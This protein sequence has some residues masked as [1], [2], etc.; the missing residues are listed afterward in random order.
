MPSGADLFEL[1]FMGPGLL[2]LLLLVLFA[3]LALLPR[4][5][6]RRHTRRVERAA[7]LIESGRTDAGLTRL[8]REIARLRHRRSTPA[9]ATVLVGVLG[10][11]ASEALVAGHTDAA[12]AA[13]TEAA[14]LSARLHPNDLRHAQVL[15]VLGRTLARLGHDERALAHLRQAVLTGDA[16][17]HAD[18]ALTVRALFAANTSMVLRRTGDTPAA[19]TMATRAVHLASI[20]PPEPVPYMQAGSGFAYTALALAQT[21]SGLDGR[22]AARTALETFRRLDQEKILPGGEGIALACYTAAYAGHRQG[23]E[24]AVDL[25]REAAERF[26]DLGRPGDALHERRL[27]DASRLLAEI[28][29]GRPATPAEDPR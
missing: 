10:H 6:H 27:A 3:I 26:S 12:L 16:A 14:E 22:V 17:D 19:L 18:Q 7:K 5:A 24:Q 29:S 20:A 1:F 9:R 25:A 23:D 2:C 15:Y 28:T 8:A 21:D 13:A 11:Y 4:S